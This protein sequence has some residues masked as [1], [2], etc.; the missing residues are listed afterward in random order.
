MDS[1]LVIIAITLAIASIINIVLTKFSISHI[2]G[3]ILTGIIVSILFNFN[4]S[5]DLHSLDLVGEFGIV[6][7]MFTIGLEMSFSR[8]GKMKKLI[9]YN[10][11]MQVGLSALIIF[12]LGYYLF[13][14]GITP[15]LVIA[16]S[17]SLSSTAIVLPYLKKSKD[18]VTPYGQRSVA[19]LIFQDLAVIPILLL[20]SF[21]SNN[22]LTLT[23]VLLKTFFYAS[24]VIIFMFT[25]GK[26]IIAWLLHFSSNARMEELFLSS[27]FTIVLGASL[28]A[29][30]MGFTYSLGAFIAGMII[31]ETK[32]HIKVESDISSY[33]DLLLGA[34]FFSIGT[35]INIEYFA[36]NLHIVL[37]ILLLVMAIKAIIIY[38]LMKNQMNK[39][40]S[41]KSAVALCQVGEFS[42]AIF[43]MALNQ[44]L[45]TDELG[46]FL[47]LVT[48]LSMILTPFMVNNIYKLASF[49]VVE[50]F[51]ADKITKINAKNHTIVCGFAIIGRVVAKELTRRGVKFLIISDNLQ[52][53][54]LARKRG[55]DA[56]FGHLDKLPVLESLKVEQSSSIIITVNTIKNK[57]MICE[58]VLDYYPNAN[59]VVKVNSLEEKADLVDLKIKS[60]VHAQ[61]ETAL[62]LV[63]KSVH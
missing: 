17:F 42:F 30:E 48:V 62:L 29:H 4:G 5:D 41:I 57:K 47:I 18:I 23:D 9:F 33:K 32:F 7:L 53:V 28:I 36:S 34:F 59:L 60:F 38:L 21:L 31:A 15:S 37:G 10:G 35:K 40:D 1:I 49:F 3:Y 16:L 50:F 20:M 58:A 8:L 25:L 43:A 46:S 13:N 27:V 52:H 22:E 6:F 63:K 54:L 51:E 26:K 56:Y 61:Y 55:Y 14:L 12:M 24:G 11:F 45:V 44:N 2:I 19:V 39:S